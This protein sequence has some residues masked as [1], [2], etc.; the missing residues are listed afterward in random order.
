MEAGN[1]RANRADLGSP[2]PIAGSPLGMGD[3]NDI[4]LVLPIEKYDEVG[5][6]LEDNPTGSMQIGWI[7][8]RRSRCR[9][10]ARQQIVA[11]PARRLDASL[12][13]PDCGQIGLAPCGFVNPQSLQ[14]PTT[15]R[16]SA[17][18]SAIE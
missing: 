18:T 16:K 15:A 11:K 14:R 7:V 12:G 1:Q 3:G 17:S 5:E 9:G 4:N 2:L 10:K 8:K 13:V 6:S